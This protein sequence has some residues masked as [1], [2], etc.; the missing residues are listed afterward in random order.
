LDETDIWATLSAADVS[1]IGEASVTVANP[2]PGGGTSSPAIATIYLQLLQSTGDAVYEPTSGLIYATVPA[3]ATTNANCVIAVNPSTG[4]VVST[5]ATGN[6]PHRLAISSD[7]SLL[8]VGLDQPGQVAQYALSS[9]TRL[10]AVQLPADPFFGQPVAQDIKVLPGSPH[11]Y[12]VSLAYT[13]IIPSAAGILVYDDQTPRANSIAGWSNSG[14]LGN[15]LLFL[16][17]AASLYGSDLEVTDYSFYRFNLTATGIS[18]KDSTPNLGGGALTTDGHLVY[19]ATGKIVDPS[20]LQLVNTF[21]PPNTLFSALL[22]VSADSHLYSVGTDFGTISGGMVLASSDLK[23]LS[24]LA[25]IHFPWQPNPQSILR[26]GSQGL[27]VRIG[28]PVTQPQFPT[29]GDAL[30]L[31]KSSIVTAV[32]D[33]QLGASGSGGLSQAVSAGQTAT[34]NLTLQSTGG[35]S[36]SVAFACNG[37]PQYATCTASPSPIALSA[38]GSATLTIEITTTQ[39]LAARA[40]TLSSPFLAVFGM[41]FAVVLLPLSEKGRSKRPYAMARTLAILVIAMGLGNTIACGGGSAT[42]PPSVHTV[43][44][45]TYTLQLTA[46]SGAAARTTNLTLIVH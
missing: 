32:P 21:T 22:P 31:L 45:G 34:Y 36:G 1:S 14:V 43:A 30:V 5:I 8:Y 11:A 40:T 6:N 9:G 44:P 18:L 3:T 28:S 15:S 25:A 33:F 13:N 35:F 29:P 16:S 39:T 4:V 2:P 38:N 7:G 12:V 41:L 23:S 37:A 20:T 27:A 42:P 10:G 46:T 24:P 19:E 26:W 17:D